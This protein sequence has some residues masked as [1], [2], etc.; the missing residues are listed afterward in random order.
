[1]IRGPK[2]DENIGMWRRKFN[3]GQIETGITP[4]K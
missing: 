1:M 4:V 3:K 2:L